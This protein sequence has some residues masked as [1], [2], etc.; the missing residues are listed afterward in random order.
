MQPQWSSDDVLT[1]VF[2]VALLGAFALLA[3]SSLVKGEPVR[4]SEMICTLDAFFMLDP[5]DHVAAK[6][7]LIGR[8]LMICKTAQGF[9]TETPILAD[10]TADVSFDPLSIGELSFS[11]TSKPFVVPRDVMQIEDAYEIRGG[12]PPANSVV[13]V[14][15]PASETRHPSGAFFL[16]GKRHGLAMRIDVNARLP[17]L[18]DIHL[19]SFKVEF[20]ESAPDIR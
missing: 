8:G 6:P 3:F 2:E 4:P 11:V 16:R 19:K 18:N 9:T 15:A 1:R 13:D 12:A 10:I 20:D 5:D 14:R 7:G 17:A